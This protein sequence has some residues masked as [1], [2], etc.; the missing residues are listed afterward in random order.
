MG[1]WCSDVFDQEV[2]G[3][4]GRLVRWGLMR[5][6]RLVVKRM[7]VMIVLF[8]C[9]KGGCGVN[10]KRVMV[11]DRGLETGSRTFRGGEEGGAGW[12]SLGLCH[13]LDVVPM[14]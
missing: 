3:V 12:S 9:V 2:L 6:G 10:Q 8:G 13:E 4:G 14:S 5:C 1:K 11:G 7:T